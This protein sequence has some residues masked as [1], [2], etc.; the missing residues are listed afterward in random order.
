MN[1]NQIIHGDSYKILPELPDKSFDTVIIDPPYGMGI[2]TW[3]KPVD[4]AFFTEQIKRIGKEFYAVFGQM[5]YIREWDRQAEKQ[6]LHFLEHIS[7]VK[8][9]ANTSGKNR[10]SRGHEEVFIYAINSKRQFYKNKGKYEDVKAPGVMFDTVSIESIKRVLSALFTEVK[11]GKVQIFRK[12]GSRLPQHKHLSSCIGKRRC[13]RNVN[14]TNVWSFLPQNRINQ[15]KNLQFHATQKPVLLQERLV[16]MLTPENGSVL[17]CFSGSGTTAIACKRLD[18]QFLCIEKEQEFYEHSVE[19]L[20]GDVWQS[21][22][23]LDT[24][25]FPEQH[26][27]GMDAYRQ[28]VNA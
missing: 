13:P 16:E 28:A 18:R 5:P 7:W 12:E 22:F 19:R 2:D 14:Y 4:V 6:G 23:D 21:E 1:M 24:R 3:D 8:R 17:D 15:N 25:L 9:M 26:V 11:T 27:V 10:L 20:E